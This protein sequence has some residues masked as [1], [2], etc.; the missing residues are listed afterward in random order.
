MI[1]KFFSKKKVAVLGLGKSGISTIN[2]LKKKGFIVY[3]WDDN[4]E[5]R[6]KVKKRGI[7]TNNFSKVNLREFT[8]LVVSPG[9]HTRGPKKHFLISKAKLKKL[10][11]I[12][13]IELF[14]R[15]NPISQYIG[16]TGTNGKSTTASLLSHVFNKLRINNSLGGNIGKPIFDLKKQK[17]GFYIL[18]ISSFQLELMKSPRFRIAVLLNIT[19]DHLDR[20]GTINKYV[21]E[22]IKIFNNQKE[23][24][25]SV[26][27]IDNKISKNLLKIVK[28][29]YYSEIFSISGL[30]ENA[31]I[32]VKGNYLNINYNSK[33]Q[34]KISKKI[35]LNKFNNFRGS[36]NYQNIAAIYSILLKLNLCN[37]D[38]IEEAIKSFPGLPHRLQSIRKINNIEYIN[39][40]KATNIDSSDKALSIFKKNIYWILGGKSKEKS[41]TKL[42]KHFPK[43]KHVFLL[44]ETK[45]LYKKYLQNFLKCTIVKNLRDAIVL[46]HKLVQEE[47]I[48]KKLN[49]GVILFSPACSSLDEWNNFEERGNSFISVVKKLNN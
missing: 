46:S 8:F 42:K 17:N 27:G 18:E 31:N 32:Y 48:K 5:I 28:K 22:K 6:K 25:F 44:G 24:D 10:E 14:F 2:F 40:S 45:Y 29:K 12:N 20:H 43:I 36:H 49:T 21:S 13:D 37:W 4:K 26:I 35:N 30:N 7:N 9:I 15:F 33:N 16:I 38:K 3:A 11:V 41:L 1:Q 34:K 23:S 19:N 39:D 47:R